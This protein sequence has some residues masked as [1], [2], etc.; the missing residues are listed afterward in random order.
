[1]RL[2]LYIHD[3]DQRAF[4]PCGR[5]S[6]N[7][8]FRAPG[9]TSYPENQG[10]IGQGWAN[11]WHF[12]DKV[13]PA[14]QAA[15]RRVY[16]QKNYSVPDQVTDGIRMKST[17]YASMRLNDALGASVAVLVVEAMMPDHF[18]EAHLRATIEST[19]VDY[20]RVIHEMRG[21]LPTPAK[22]AESGL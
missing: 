10:C 20:A 16:N 21:Y 11:G 3:S 5:Y 15:A 19:A 18:A 8:I 14:N 7:P 6:T 9:R 12:D 17:Q 4:I 22:A 13:P 2:S 1:V